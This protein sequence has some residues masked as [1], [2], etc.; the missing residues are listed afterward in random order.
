MRRDN[1]PIELIMLLPLI[2]FC[3]IAHAGSDKK[4]Q[5]TMAEDIMRPV[6]Y[7]MVYSYNCLI[8][9]L[10]LLQKGLIATAQAICLILNADLGQTTYFGGV[11]TM[12]NSWC[13]FFQALKGTWHIEYGAEDTLHVFKR[14][15]P[16][17]L[18]G[19]WGALNNGETY[20]LARN[21]MNA[22]EIMVKVLGKKESAAAAAAAKQKTNPLATLLGEEHEHDALVYDQTMGRW[23]KTTLR[24]Y[25]CPVFGHIV[26]LVHFVHDICAHVLK[27]L[28]KDNENGRIAELVWFKNAEFI[29]QFDDAA[30]SDE[31]WRP[32]IDQFPATCPAPVVKYCALGCTVQA[33]SDYNMRFTEVI[34]RMDSKTLLFAKSPPGDQCEDRM[35]LAKE[36]VAAKSLD[37]L[38]PT[39]FKLLCMFRK[40]MVYASKTRKL[41]EGHEDLYHYTKDIA[42]RISGHTGDVE[43]INSTIKNVCGRSPHVKQACVNARVQIG[44]RTSP[45]S[46]TWT[47]KKE[48]IHNLINELVNFWEDKEEVE[49][50]PDRFANAEAA[51]HQ[52]TPERRAGDVLWAGRERTR[53]AAHGYGLDGS[54]MKK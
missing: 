29:K 26:K 27:W 43:G 28:H 19:R 48:A 38:G 41:D 22:K 1:V 13:E 49:A 12:L 45:G 42:K 47:I 14:Y 23:R 3:L 17:A 4:M 40:E 16:R 34:E 15:P 11:A 46:K 10:H 6:P 37:E 51:H 50:D 7:L 33:A 9:Q 24:L 32:I 39:P 8:H 2:V 21:W 30:R 52:V 31:Q 36:M 25:S 53:W 5:R 54:F 18:V 35:A 44:Q 20:L